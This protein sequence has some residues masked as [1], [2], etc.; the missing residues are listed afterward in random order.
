[1]VGDLSGVEFVEEGAEGEDVDGFVVGA[2]LE[3]FLG[4]VDGGSRELHG[5]GVELRLRGGGS[6]LWRARP[7]S[8]SLIA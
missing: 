5:A 8:Q 7:K 2:F 3:E 6:T 4:H 1:M